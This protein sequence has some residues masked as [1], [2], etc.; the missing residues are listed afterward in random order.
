[1]IL[2]DYVVENEKHFLED[3]INMHQRK[4]SCGG[5]DEAIHQ[6]IDILF[7]QEK[8]KDP[9]A[10]EPCP[11]IFQAISSLLADKGPPDAIKEKYK[12]AQ[13]PLKEHSNTLPSIGTVLNH[14]RYRRKCSIA[15][16]IHSVAL[17]IK[18]I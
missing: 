16:K 3:L 10:V 18:L 9:E 4:M 12:E 11:E 14:F 1:M 5:G 2:G 7:K 13:I 8:E 15:L 17:Q 6:L